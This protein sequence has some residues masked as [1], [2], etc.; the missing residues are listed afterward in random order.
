MLRTV[1]RKYGKRFQKTNVF[2]MLLLSF[3]SVLMLPVVVFFGLYTQIERIMV[4]NATN[5]NLAMLEQARQTVDGRLE[6]LHLMSR[7]ITSHPR[8]ELLLRAESPVTGPE[9]YEF[10]AFMNEMQRYRNYGGFV[11]D[12]YIYFEKSNTVLTPSFKAEPR[13]VFT[14]IYGYGDWTF[15]QWKDNVFEQA[16]YNAYLPAKNVRRE[17]SNDR[18]VVYLQ[19]LPFGEKVSPLGTLVMYIDGNKLTGML[20]QIAEATQ[21]S[22]YITNAE[23]DVIIGRGPMASIGRQTGERMMTVS[24]KSS[25]SGWEYVSVVPETVVLAKVNMLKT[26]AVAVLLFCLTTGVAAC[27]FL[28]YRAYRPLREIIAYLRNKKPQHH[29]DCKNE[30]EFIKSMVAD[31]ME[32]QLEMETQLFKQRPA[33]RSNF[34][35]RLLK[36]Y[37]RISDVSEHSVAFMGLT[38]PHSHVAVALIKLND[39]S[40]FIRSDTESEW[41]LVRFIAG[42]LAEEQHPLK[43]YSVELEKDTIAA[44]LIVPEGLSFDKLHDWAEQL[45]RVIEERFKTKTVIALSG[46]RAGLES[47]PVCYAESEKALDYAIFTAHKS[48]VFYDEMGQTETYYDFPVEAEIQL[49]NAVKSGDWP[50]AEAVIDSLFHNNFKS[51]RMTPEMGRLLFANLT[52]TLFKLLNSLRVK[53][54]ELFHSSNPLETITESKSVDEMYLHLKSMFEGVCRHVTEQRGDASVAM[55]HS[56]KQYLRDHYADPMLSLVTIANHFQITSQYLSAFFKKTSGT[57][58]TDYLAKIR[59]EEAKR[60]MEDPSMTISQIASKV[61]YTNDVGFIR[62]FKRYEG[63]TPGKYKETLH[64]SRNQSEL[65]NVYS[66]S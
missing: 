45:K 10:V 32:K 3:F 48:I 54:E 9:R 15:E 12:F 22:I 24:T 56:I 37:V 59:I 52:S 35:L 64:A 33:I 1:A 50:K 8:L 62:L 23:G 58:L 29:H 41:A 40:A 19:S 6:E 7:Y 25:V 28:S 21:G 5:A 13:I 66:N 57:N 2:V 42:K 31:S 14:Q 63:I 47:A 61:G 39:A 34:L 53:Y 18:K 43:S 16:H 4:E 38:L 27:F 51:K 11:S 60:L 20:N 36:G 55:L 65:T 49:I 17:Y 26:A 44:L 46:V 30:Y